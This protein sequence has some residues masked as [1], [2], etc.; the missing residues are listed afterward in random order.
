MEL[1]EVLR[2]VVVEVERVVE[3]E[4]EVNWVVDEL[5]D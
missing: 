1:V 3:L 4:L 2:V 5:V